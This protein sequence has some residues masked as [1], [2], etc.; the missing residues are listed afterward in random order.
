[1]QIRMRRV[2]IAV[3]GR[4]GSLNEKL[5]ASLHHRGHPSVDINRRTSDEPR[6]FRDEKCHQRP[7]LFWLPEPLEWDA[8]SHFRMKLFQCALPTPRPPEALSLCTF[9]IGQ[10]DRIHQNIFCCVVA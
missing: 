10:T 6:L 3:G 5:S 2:K 8:F 9:D 1:M 4:L 7:Y